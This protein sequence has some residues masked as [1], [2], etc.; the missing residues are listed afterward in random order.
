[1]LQSTQTNGTQ[2]RINSLLTWLESIARDTEGIV[3]EQ[4]PLL[5]QEILIWALWYH[6]MRVGLVLAVWIIVFC[7]LYI[8]VRRAIHEMGITKKGDSAPEWTGAVIIPSAFFAAVWSIVSIVIIPV[9]VFRFTQVIVAP[10]AY[11]LEYVMRNF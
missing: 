9:S 8:P 1:M 6:S 5:V 7:C 3:V 2:E 10:R 4:T 11:L